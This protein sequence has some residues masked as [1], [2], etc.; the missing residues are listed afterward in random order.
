MWRPVETDETRADEHEKGDTADKPARWLLMWFPLLMVFLGLA[1]WVISQI[2]N[3]LVDRLGLSASL[4]GALDT[5]VIPSTQL[6]VELW[7]F[8]ARI[9]NILKLTN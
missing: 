8:Y 6:Q 1:G 9:I 7:L 2:G 5:A 3:Q 4:V